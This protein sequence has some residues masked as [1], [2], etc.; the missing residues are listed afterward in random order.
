M[1]FKSILNKFSSIEALPKAVEAPK[2]AD[3]IRLDEGTE[4]RVLAGVTKLTESVI[5]EKSVSKAQQKFMGMVH[6]TKKGEKAPSKEVAKA[7]KGMSDKEAEKFASTKH[8]GLPEKKA[9]TEDIDVTEEM[10]VGDTKKSATGGTIEKTKTGIKHT[11]KPWDGEDHT[12]P[13]QKKASK[14]AMTGAERRDQKAAD[15]E[16]AKASKEYE[17]KHPGSVTRHK[18]KEAA[19]P[20]FLDMDKDGDK[21]EPMKKAV[22]DKKKGAAPKKG[23]N[24]FAKKKV[25]ETLSFRK[26]MQIVKESQGDFQVDPIDQA[27]WSWAERVGKNKFTESVQAQAFAAVT[28]E[29]MGGEWNLHKI[30]K[31]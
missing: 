3:P 16:Q 6:A 29:K 8:K 31:E 18:M 4:L 15:K 23:V 14:K 21:K 5:A 2:L 10:K 22:A 24:P 1:D 7:A 20:D 17:K 30:I 9:K 26:A 13:A 25:D 27:L 28:Y 11:A 19:K 12:E